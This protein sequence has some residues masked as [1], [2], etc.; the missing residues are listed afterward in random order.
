MVWTQQQAIDL[1]RKIE[2]IAPQYGCHVALTGGCLYRDGERKDA[3]ILFYR[4]RQWEQIDVVGL[5]AALVEIGVDPGRDHG[6]CHKATYEGR[7][8]DF[9][10][11]E[12]PGLEYPQPDADDVLRFDP[13]AED[14]APF[15]IGLASP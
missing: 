13:V 14:A 10:F 6:W 1:C 12:R 9:F 11:P 4:I 7:A 5:M 15:D 8:I 2:A 3:D